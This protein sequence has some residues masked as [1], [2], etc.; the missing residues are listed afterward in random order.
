[1]RMLLKVGIPVEAGNR[2]IKDGELPKTISTFVE[3]MKPEA[4]FFVGENGLRTGYFFFDLKDASTI[5]V[6][7]EPFF[8]KL[9]ATIELTPAMNIEE[10]KAGIARAM[11]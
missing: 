4:V 11:K 10:L 9:N 8:V 1:M 6:A 2:A 5:P 3:Q 7:C